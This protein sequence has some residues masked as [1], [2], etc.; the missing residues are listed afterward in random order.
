MHSG[1]CACICSVS[2]TS[3]TAKLQMQ[4]EDSVMPSCCGLTTI[5]LALVLDHSD[6]SDHSEPCCFGQEKSIRE[7]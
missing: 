7:L 1:M 5:S 4:E 2:Q 6:V 3:V